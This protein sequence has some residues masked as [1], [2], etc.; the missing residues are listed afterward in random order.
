MSNSVSDGVLQFSWLTEVASLR[1]SLDE[2][3]TRLIMLANFI[4]S[5]PDKPRK[6]FDIFWRRKGGKKKGVWEEIFGQE[7][8]GR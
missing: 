1:F 6:R 4:P 7:S 2:D 8:G 5:Y 3:N